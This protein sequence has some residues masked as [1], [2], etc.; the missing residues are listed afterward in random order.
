MSGVGIA[1]S[2]K[3]TAIA[4]GLKSIEGLFAIGRAIG[5][6]GHWIATGS[7]SLGGRFASLLV[8]VYRMWW[9]YRRSSAAW[10]VHGAQW[11]TR[12]LASRVAFHGIFVVVVL[13][14]AGQTLHAREFGGFVGERPLLAA[15]IST[16]DE[17]DF[18]EEIVLG[19]AMPASRPM[20]RA[21][22]V[23]TVFQP[24]VLSAEATSIAPT[25][26][27]GFAVVQPILT[28]AAVEESGRAGIQLYTIE[29]GDTLSTIAERFGLLTTTILW[30]NKLQVWS[31]IQPGTT[32]RILPTDG[33]SHT[34][35]RGETLESVAKK[36][37]GDA[38]EIL[39]LNKLV[40][41][42]DIDVGDLLIIPGGRPP[43]VIA[44]PVVR[45]APARASLPLPSV[46]GKF[47]WPS[48]SGYRI[49][50]YFT[51]RH[52]GVDI[53]VAQGT[54]AFASDAGTVI[55][56]GW[57]R[58]YGYQVTIDH[59]NG[60]KTRYAHNSKLL[61]VKGQQVARGQEIA[62]VGSTGR[63]TGPHIHFEVFANGV[64]VNPFQYLR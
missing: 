5:H 22:S 33:V 30:E 31:M 17:A 63:S 58:G 24:T 57:I 62:L 23:S 6:V 34:V 56:S 53:A 45:R 26:V 55:S 2:L 46:P 42:D 39:E 10:N 61:V 21:A 37:S 35:V 54:P 25:P 28:D 47:F 9:T 41:A 27:A 44:P 59:G 16:S 40:D 51:W 36:F 7:T 20:F 43:A 32:L 15:F 13:G 19:P 14:V 52:H 48:T 50:Q 49:S 4:L 38:E 8:P 60:L 29:P 64:R 12:V 1:R 18:A 3:K 11:F